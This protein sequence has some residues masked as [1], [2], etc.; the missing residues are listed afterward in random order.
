[1]SK[2]PL[3]K[4][5][6]NDSMNQWAAVMKAPFGKLGVK[7]EFSDNS[8][9]IS[10][11]FYVSG[12]EP[13][14]SPQNA[15]AQ[16][17]CDQAMVYFDDPSFQFHLPIM[18]KGTPFQRKVWDHID[19]IACGEVKSYAEVA[20]ALKSAPRAVGGACGANPYPLIVPCHRV[21]ARNGIGGFAKEDREGYHRNIKTWL[22][23]HEGIH[24]NSS[25]K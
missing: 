3:L 2:K 5:A 20:N 1:M 13:L 19:T 17:F 18:L 7:T 25:R 24:F 4:S 8:L 6:K 16:Q 14:I 10:E 9:C 12:Q 11:V 15:L 22:L 21:V 23:Q